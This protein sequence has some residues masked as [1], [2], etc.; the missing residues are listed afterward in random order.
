MHWHN[1]FKR[2]KRSLSVKEITEKFLKKDSLLVR[3]Q[4]TLF[5]LLYNALIKLK[6]LPEEYV[7]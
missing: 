7:F 1:Y 3:L 6:E 4:I 5:V 2:S